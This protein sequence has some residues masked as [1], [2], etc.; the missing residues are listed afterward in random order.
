MLACLYLRQEDL[1]NIM[2][3]D[4]SFMVFL[5]CGKGSLMPLMLQASKAW[6]HNR[7]NDGVTQPLRQ[8]LF[9]T[10]IE[11]LSKRAHMLKLD[12]PDDVLVKD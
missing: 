10:L 1:L 2:S 7:Q 6:H 9:R 4:R 11:E 5:Q 3:M 12:A 8:F